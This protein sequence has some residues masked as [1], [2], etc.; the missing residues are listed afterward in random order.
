MDMEDVLNATISHLTLIIKEPQV[1]ANT[2]VTLKLALLIVQM[3]IHFI[4]ETNALQ[5]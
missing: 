4:M 1:Q 5:D 2:I 3:A